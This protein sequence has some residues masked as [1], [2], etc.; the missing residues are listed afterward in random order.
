MTDSNKPFSEG[1]LVTF[2]PSAKDLQ[3]FPYKTC[4]YE[5]NGIFL[6]Y[7]KIDI[8]SYPSWND[9]TGYGVKVQS[10]ETGILIRKIG[11]PHGLALFSIDWPSLDLSIYTVLLNGREV[12]VFG[13]DLV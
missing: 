7:E 2:N 8:H 5:G 10:G 9:F 6:L 11:M 1:Q 4:G 12:Q 3:S 13:V